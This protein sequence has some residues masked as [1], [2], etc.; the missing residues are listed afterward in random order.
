MG[1]LVSLRLR[2]V[3]FWVGNLLLRYWESLI[4]LTRVVFDISLPSDLRVS[5]VPSKTA[6]SK[7]GNAIVG[8]TSTTSVHESASG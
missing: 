4:D 7:S 6:L 2:V 5:I 8:A 3:F 1:N